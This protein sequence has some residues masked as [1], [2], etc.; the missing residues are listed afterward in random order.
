MIFIFI[1]LIFLAV[2]PEV[3]VKFL[4][5]SYP[6]FLS[7]CA[8]ESFYLTI[9]IYVSFSLWGVGY[10]MEKDICVRVQQR[11][12]M[13]SN[14]HESNMI[15]LNVIHANET[16]ILHHRI[17]VMNEHVLFLQKQIIHRR[18]SRDRVLEVYC[19]SIRKFENKFARSASKIFDPL[20]FNIKGNVLSDYLQ[21]A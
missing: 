11:T 14:K 18:K 8:R 6:G 21:Y 13:L 17:N 9:T 15:E 7:E 2:I 3:L 1:Y 19:K 5:Y 12:R 4:Q 20:S 10:A 16:S